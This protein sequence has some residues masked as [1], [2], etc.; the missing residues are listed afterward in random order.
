MKIQTAN[1]WESKRDGLILTTSTGF[2]DRNGDW[3]I[4]NGFAHQLTQRF[5]HWQDIPIQNVFGQAIVKR[6]VNVDGFYEY[7]LITPSNYPEFNIGLFQTKLKD[8]TSIDL[9][10]KSADML[11]IW[12]KNN[13]TEQVHINLPGTSS[14]T[15]HDI[16]SVIRYLP[17]AV[18]FWTLQPWWERA[19]YDFHLP[20][21]Q[22]HIDAV[23]SITGG[24]DPDNFFNQ[25]N[26]CIE[27]M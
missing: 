10:K 18:T 22:K 13:P 1:F 8:I 15:H 21:D 27:K 12:C 14:V 9:I 11:N 6:G 23:L 7:G 4:P 3:I 26:V 20:Y 17:N 16:Y 5:T 25:E 2:L 19:H 24:E